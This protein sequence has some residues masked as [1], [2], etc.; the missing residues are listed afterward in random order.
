MGLRLTL[1]TAA[2]AT[3]LLVPPPVSAGQT[4]C[5]ACHPPH[6]TNLRGCTGCHRGND[7]TGRKEVAHDGMIPGRYSWFTIA[8]APPVARGKKL[9]ELYACRRCHTAQGRGN[10]LAMELDGLL[11]TRRPREIAL[12]IAKPAQ[13]MPDFHLAEGE[14]TCLVNAILAGE[15]REAGKRAETPLVVHFADEGKREENVFERECGGCHRMLNEKH[16]ALGRGDVG[17]NLSGFFTPFYPRSYSQNEPWNAEHL[18]KWLENPRRIRRNAQMPPVRLKTEE[19]GRLV[20]ILG[21]TK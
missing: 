20:E 4:G 5:L 19:F 1:L 8:G 13:C 18:R 14:V 12:A 6:Y 16:G 9:L 7:A 10:R 15:K 17:P 21:K 2:L 3:C 11:A